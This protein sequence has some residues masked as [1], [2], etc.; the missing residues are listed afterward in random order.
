MFQVS[1]VDANDPNA[2]YL[3]IAAEIKLLMAAPEM[4]WSAVDSGEFL[5]ASQLFLFA[6]HVHT[7]LTLDDARPGGGVSAAQIAA[8]FPVVSRQW[9][10][11]AHFHDAILSGC[12]KTLLGWDE[13]EDAAAER[14]IEALAALVLLKGLDT[15]ELFQEVMAL[16]RTALE[17][18][19]S[20]SYHL[21][22]LSQL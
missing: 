2:P 13:A 10:S 1:T 15:G 18:Q 17:E 3:A 11:I 6:R 12:R 19:A 22:D 8:W 5:R 4:I 9:A 7:G 16:R 14:C 21:L 20:L